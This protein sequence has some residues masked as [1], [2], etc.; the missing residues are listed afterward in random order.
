L[1][2][3][4]IERAVRRLRRSFGRAAVL[5]AD[6]G[7][8]QELNIEAEQD[9]AEE[10]APCSGRGDWAMTVV[11]KDQPRRVKCGDGQ[12]VSLR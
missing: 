5:L 9:R 7:V 12:A 6:L 1:R 4:E 2:L 8:T 10:A 11:T 3:S